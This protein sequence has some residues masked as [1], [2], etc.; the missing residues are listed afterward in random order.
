MKQPLHKYVTEATEKRNPTHCLYDTLR[1]AQTSEHINSASHTTTHLLCIRASENTT[2]AFRNR[3]D[4]TEPANQSQHSVIGPARH[5][6]PKIL[7]SVLPA[8][9][10]LIMFV[11]LERVRRLH[12]RTR[13]HCDRISSHWT[14]QCSWEQYS[15]SKYMKRISTSS[16]PDRVP[17]YSL[18]DLDH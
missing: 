1:T 8:Q 4:C 5:A 11:S 13:T 10:P 3:R 7:D 16:H 9:I 6:E 18:Q 2:K 17:I 14:T 15:N 12:K